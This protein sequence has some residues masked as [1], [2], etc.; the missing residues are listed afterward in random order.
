MSLLLAVMHTGAA[1]MHNC[2]V[3]CCPCSSTNA[4]SGCGGRRHMPLTPMPGGAGNHRRCQGERPSALQ[5]VPSNGIGGGIT[6]QAEPAACEPV[7]G[8][9]VQGRCRTRQAQY[10]AGVHTPELH[11]KLCLQHVPQCSDSAGSMQAAVRHRGPANSGLPEAL[12]SSTGS[13]AQAAR[14]PPSPCACHPRQW[15]PPRRLRPA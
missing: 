6:M 5:R 9:W 2:E 11:T 12:D 14:Q 10:S 7:E 3:S 8:R 1:L 4:T 13:A 15:Q